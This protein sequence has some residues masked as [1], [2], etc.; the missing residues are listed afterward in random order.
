MSGQIQIPLILSA[1]NKHSMETY[2]GQDTKHYSLFILLP[3]EQMI[4]TPQGKWFSELFS[5]CSAAFQSTKSLGTSRLGLW[6]LPVF[7]YLIKVACPTFPH[8]SR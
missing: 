5:V 7:I 1:P 3:D 4:P 2:V 6:M 8:G